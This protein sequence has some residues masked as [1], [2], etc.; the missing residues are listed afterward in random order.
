MLFEGQFYMLVIIGAVYTKLGWMVYFEILM[1][2]T[3]L[4]AKS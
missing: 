1:H 2:T 4:D 3:G